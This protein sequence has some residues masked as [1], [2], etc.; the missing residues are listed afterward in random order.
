MIEQV[1]ESQTLWWTRVGSPIG[2]LTV[3]R[4]ATGLLRVELPRRDSEAA[5]EAR[6]TILAEARG[7][8][9][10]RDPDR[11]GPVR[12]EL[13]EYFAG[14]RREFT[15]PVDWSGSDGYTRVVLRALYESVPYGRVTSY[16]EL[17]ARTGVPGGARAVG[18]VMGANP[19]PIVVP[20]HRVLAAAG[21]GGF[22][23]GPGMKRAL[24]ALEGSAPAVPA[25]LF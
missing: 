6:V 10:V 1:T 19:V 20:C 13:A 17:A 5:A 21:L 18:Q 2:T 7:A 3:V 11:L 14:D 15:I 8:R 24:L 9:A 23:G 4:S 12:T 16:G 22:G 25:P